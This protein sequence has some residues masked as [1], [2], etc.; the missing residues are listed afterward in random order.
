MHIFK[1]PSVFMFAAWFALLF[2]DLLYN[3]SILI[4]QSHFPSTVAFA[5][6]GLA[7]KAETHIRR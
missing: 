1:V 6:A 5:C 2:Q 3:D 4:N 7:K